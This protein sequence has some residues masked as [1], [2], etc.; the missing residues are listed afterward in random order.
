MS[1]GTEWHWQDAVDGI[2][3][4]I[5]VFPILPLA[6]S[7]SSSLLPM[8]GRN[9]KNLWN[10]RLI[11][12]SL[13]LSTNCQSSSQITAPVH[14]PSVN[15]PSNYLIP[16]QYLFIYLAPLHPIIFISILHILPLQIYHSSVLLAI[17]Y[18]LCHH[19]FFF[20]AFTSLILH[21]HLICTHIVYSMCNSVLL[22][23]SLCF[24]LAR[25]QF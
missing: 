10:W 19:G 5:Y 21:A 20:F 2:E 18:L 24:I 3:Y 22:F 14:S 25:S 7:P 16:I 15:S 17:L 6:A 13:A 11:S 23:V 12:S 8:T 1:D 4:S 9:Y